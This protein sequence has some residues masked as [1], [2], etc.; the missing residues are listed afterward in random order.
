MFQPLPALIFSCFRILGLQLEDD[1]AEAGAVTF[2]GVALLHSVVLRRGSWKW[3]FAALGLALMEIFAVQSVA[4]GTGYSKCLYDDDCK[5]GTVCAYLHTPSMPKDSFFRQAI[6]VDCN[7]I[8]PWQ[9]KQPLPE[10]FTVASYLFKPRIDGFQMA[11]ARPGVN[12]G[13]APKASEFCRSQLEA[14]WVKQWSNATNFDTV[15]HVSRS[16]SISP[17]SGSRTPTNSL[18]RLVACSSPGGRRIVSPPQCLFVREALRRFGALDVLVMLMAFFL[19][20]ASICTERQQQLFNKHLRLM[21]MPPPWRSPKAFV[22]RVIEALL[23]ALLPS[24]CLSMALLLFGGDLSSTAVLLNGVAIAFVLVI[25]DELPNV[26]LSEADKKAVDSFAETA[27]NS[28]K[29]KIIKEQGTY[30]AVVSLLSLMCMLINAISGPCDQLIIG[31]LFI[32]MLTPP[33]CIFVEEFVAIKYALFRPTEKEAAPKGLANKLRKLRKLVW[34]ALPRVLIDCFLQFAGFLA[35]AVASVNLY[36]LDTAIEGGPGLLPED[37]IP[38][39][40]RLWSS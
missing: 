4:I 33:L 13:V 37:M 19:V 6:C 1:E 28:S 18:L 36:L 24:V 26:V 15:R 17:P 11:P 30:T 2:Y 5:L 39:V 29:L 10:W 14:P 22:F 27:G 25:D 31:S 3:I 35:V 21:L 40:P 38:D 20:C 32:S 12:F 7:I 34:A 23:G 16:G 9:G 8:F